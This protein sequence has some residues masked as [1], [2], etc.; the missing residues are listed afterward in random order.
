MT[1]TYS[2][3]MKCSFSSCDMRGAIDIAKVI[4]PS[5]FRIVVFCENVPDIEYHGYT[6]KW[7]AFDL[8]KKRINEVC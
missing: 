1:A 8:G 2:S 4:M 6:G 5:V 7:T 3:K